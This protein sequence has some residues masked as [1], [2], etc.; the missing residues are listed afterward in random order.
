M[1]REVEKCP[2][3]HARPKFDVFTLTYITIADAMVTKMLQV[4]KT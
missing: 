2:I 4:P 1:P 3:L